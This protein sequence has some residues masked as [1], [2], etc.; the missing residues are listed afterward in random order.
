MSAGQFR[1]ALV[2]FS[3]H[4]VGTLSGAGR[5][6]ESAVAM[7]ASHITQGMRMTNRQFCADK[8]LLVREMLE[9]ADAYLKEARTSC[10][11]APADESV[12]A[13]ESEDRTMLR[14]AYDHVLDL[15]DRVRVLE[16]RIH[17]VESHL[18]VQLGGSPS[19]TPRKSKAA[20]G[21]ASP[22]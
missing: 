12:E 13:V 16:K 20:R 3:W 22:R 15:R 21:G 4:L 2:W 1:H 9:A 11:S 8:L 6:Y 17:E 18:R 14:L 5:C 19:G 10:E 7:E